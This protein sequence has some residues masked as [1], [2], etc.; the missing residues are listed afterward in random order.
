[1][2]VWD[3]VVDAKSAD[4]TF[5]IC[6]SLYALET[7]LCPS[8]PGHV[9]GRYI[10]A[11]KD[12][13]AIHLNNWA[14]FRFSML[15]EEAKRLYDRVEDLGGF[16]CNSIYVTK[17]FSG[18][19]SDAPSGSIDVSTGLETNF[20]DDLT[21]VKADVCSVESSLSILKSTVGTMQP[22][23]VWLK[24]AIGTL[25][26]SLEELTSQGVGNMVA[27]KVEEEGRSCYIEG[28]DNFRGKQVSAGA[29][30]IAGEISNT[31]AKLLSY[32][33]GKKI[34]PKDILL[35]SE[36]VARFCEFSVSRW[37]MSCLSPA[38]CLTREVINISSTYL[39]DFDCDCWFLPSLFSE[40]AE[41][42]GS[43]EGDLNLI[44]A[45]ITKCGLCR[46]QDR[47]HQC[48]QIY[49]LIHDTLDNHWFLVVVNMVDADC[50][51]WDSNPH[52]QAKDQRKEHANASFNLVDQRVR[53]ALEIVKH[54][55]NEV[56]DR[57]KL[58]NANYIMPDISY[59]D[60]V[61]RGRT[62]A[63]LGRFAG[64]LGQCQRIFVPLHEE[65]HGGHWW[66]MVVHPIKLIAEIWDS[67]ASIG[68]CNSRLATARVAL[69]HLDD[70]LYQ[71][72]IDVISAPLYY[73][74]DF[75]TIVPDNVPQQTNGFDCGIYV[76]RHMQYYGIE[77]WTE[78]PI[79]ERY[80][81]IVPAQF[82]GEQIVGVARIDIGKNG[83]Q[84]GGKDSGENRVQ[85]I[86]RGKQTS[87]K[88]G[89]GG[90]CKE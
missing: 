86:N 87:N 33:F 79:N 88:I 28:K 19:R 34:N 89:Q 56:Y 64:H 12:P 8:S 85:G 81:E 57:V 62:F 71:D 59:E 1:M 84:V 78:P 75:K 24:A 63:Q 48:K 37:D 73:F 18:V 54:P 13:N 44:S 21:Q 35:C 53:I 43:K 52:P 47:L 9:D 31:D 5:K 55:K 11:V 3:G 40:A 82:G 76:I 36:E 90:R 50:K 22:D 49:I 61:D 83:G 42:A 65:E 68:T 70:V 25:E 4:D 58:E 29:C 30:H 7:L 39:F 72:P 16:H 14:T 32:L 66:L 77:W 27:G 17:R 74:G 23:I 80:R 46:Y 51:I 67:N 41:K 6:F 26:K 15:L 45:T 20:V 60:W 38:Q 2:G 10:L 69:R